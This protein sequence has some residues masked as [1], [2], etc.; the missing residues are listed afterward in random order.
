MHR[1]PM[2]KPPKGY[3]GG[4]SDGLRIGGFH[5]GGFSSDWEGHGNVITTK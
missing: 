2:R 1:N 4:D 5:S 3:D